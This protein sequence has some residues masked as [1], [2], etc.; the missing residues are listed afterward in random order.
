MGRF[1][2]TAPKAGGLMNINQTVTICK[3]AFDGAAR[4]SECI[5]VSH[6]RPTTRRGCDYDNMWW[7]LKIYPQANTAS[8]ARHRQMRYWRDD[9]APEVGEL[10]RVKVRGSKTIRYAYF[11]EQINGPT[12]ES[13][14]PEMF[15]DREDMPV[16]FHMFARKLTDAGYT[17]I[18][19]HLENIILCH[20]RVRWIAVDFGELSAIKTKRS[21]A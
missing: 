19:Q 5:F 21:G 7:A 16:A 18:D 14:I 17:D 9:L 8:D 20:R 3:S 15:K 4:G 6:V 1:I 11:T 12:A 2:A 10:V 13:C